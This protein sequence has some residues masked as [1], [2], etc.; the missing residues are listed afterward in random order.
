M[1]PEALRA[2]DAVREDE[3][4]ANVINVTSPDLLF[5]DWLRTRGNGTLSYLDELMPFEERGAPAIS[6]IDGHPLTLGWLGGA[7]GCAMLPLGV[8]SFG[9]SGSIQALYHKHH[10]DVE[11]IVEGIARLLVKR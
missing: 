1:L 7:L 10:I 9:E 6:V 8:V 11:A 4:Y 2:S 5:A 3:V